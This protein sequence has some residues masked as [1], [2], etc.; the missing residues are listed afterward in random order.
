MWRVISGKNSRATFTPAF[1]AR[2][3]P[4]LTAPL[5]A[6]LD[7]LPRLLVRL[8]APQVEGKIV[9]VS[10][11]SGVISQRLVSFDRRAE[12]RTARAHGDTKG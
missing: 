1:V 11:A 7:A 2:A 3:I 5:L 9:L 10:S 12:L 8:D 6:V 4:K